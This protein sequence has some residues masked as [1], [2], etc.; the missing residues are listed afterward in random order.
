MILAAKKN[1]LSNEECMDILERA[2]QIWKNRL[3]RTIQI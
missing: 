1:D 3:A 2:K